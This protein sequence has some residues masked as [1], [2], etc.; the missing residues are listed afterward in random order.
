M[1]TYLLV[2]RHPE[3]YIGTAHAAAA[4]K[5]WF[6]R[7]GSHLVDR[8][9]SLRADTRRHVRNATAA[10][11]LHTPHGQPIRRSRGTGQRLPDHRRRGRSRSWPPHPSS[12]ARAPRPH[13]LSQPHRD[14]VS[15][16]PPLPASAPDPCEPGIRPRA[17]GADR[18]RQSCGL[19]PAQTPRARARQRTARQDGSRALA[20]VPGERGSRRRSNGEGR[21]APG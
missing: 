9:R 1:N 17:G 14:L 5:T 8:Q 19:R 13:L 20:G 7:L 11:R 10:R 6:S 18:L 4:W 16:H 15:L 12:W 3:N 21:R 2:H